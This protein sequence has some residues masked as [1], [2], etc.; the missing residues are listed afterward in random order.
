MAVTSSAKKLFQPHEGSAQVNAPA[1]GVVEYPLSD[2]RLA[3]VLREVEPVVDSH[4]QPKGIGEGSVADGENLN[5]IVRSA[6]NASTDEI[7]SVIYL[8]NDLR[9]IL[10]KE[11]ERV[12]DEII[13][14]TNRKQS[15]EAEMK[16][17][18][19]SL[20]RWKQKSI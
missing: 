3:D 14:Y 11:G 18:F 15:L 10:R 2:R 4:Q 13:G 19:D 12:S 20:E 6:A 1:S 16:T 8:L 5:L 17:I 7:A 9:E